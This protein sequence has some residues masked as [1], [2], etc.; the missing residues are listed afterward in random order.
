MLLIIIQRRFVIVMI[1]AGTPLL[2]RTCA[3]AWRWRAW[4]KKNKF[5]QATEIKKLTNTYIWFRF[6]IPIIKS[7]IWVLCIKKWIHY[8]ILFHYS[9]C[10][11]F[12]H[13]HWTTIEKIWEMLNLA[14]VY[15]HWSD[16]QSLGNQYKR[17]LV[18]VDK[19]RE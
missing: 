8:C 2:I 5:K 15:K 7:K 9:A 4:L 18:L 11:L 16:V 17:P 1:P 3:C 13:Q 6:P 10:F 19:F 14:P 12:R